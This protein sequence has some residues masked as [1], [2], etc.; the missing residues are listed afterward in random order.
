VGTE[1]TRAFLCFFTCAFLLVAACAPPGVGPTSPGGTEGQ[2]TAK[3][4]LVAA[5]LKPNIPT[6]RENGGDRIYELALGGLG[7]LDTWGVVHPQLAEVVPSIE[8]GLWRVFP[9]GR[10]ETT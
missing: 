9:D 1:R 8:N 10:I 7:R 3:K 6:I 4:H 5:L 2:P